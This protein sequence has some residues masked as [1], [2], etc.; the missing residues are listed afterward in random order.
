[1]P[2]HLNLQEAIARLPSA[3]TE[4]RKRRIQRALDL[5]FKHK[6]LKPEIQAMQGDPYHSVV[7]DLALQ[8]EAERLEREELLDKTPANW[9]QPVIMGGAF[10]L[11]GLY[12]VWMI[13]KAM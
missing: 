7:R 1:M 5:S 11:S 13:A 3:D 10:A 4:A 8:T 6:Y 12:C 9:D 2:G